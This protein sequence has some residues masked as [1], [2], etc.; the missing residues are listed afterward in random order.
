MRFIL[1]KLS[2]TNVSV[3]TVSAAKPSTSEYQSDSLIH[4]EIQND[5]VINS[6]EGI[7][8]ELAWLKNSVQQFACANFSKLEIFL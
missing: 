2:V 7:E 3:Q 6:D 4:S 8:V 5:D 1:I